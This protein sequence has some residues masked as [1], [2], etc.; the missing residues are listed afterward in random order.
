MVLTSVG[1]P[2][3]IIF[4]YRVH[5]SL[6]ILLCDVGE[7]KPLRTGISTSHAWWRVYRVADILLYR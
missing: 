1:Q 2:S 5:C 7:E 4:S 6:D 3:A